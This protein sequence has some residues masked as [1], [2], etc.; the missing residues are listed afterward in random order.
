IIMVSAF[1]REE[2]VKQ[3]EKIGIRTFLMKPVNPDL[4]RDILLQE[5]GGTAAETSAHTTGRKP[6]SVRADGLR[7]L[8]VEDNPLNQEVATEIL[9]SAGI[10]VE[11]ASNGKEAVEAVVKHPYDLVLMDVQMPVM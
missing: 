3:A 5:F 9:T 4:L 6:E 1:G 10:S 8:L 11:V 2:I 7:V